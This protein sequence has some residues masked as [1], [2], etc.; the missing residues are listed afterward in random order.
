MIGK[1]LSKEEVNA[2]LIVALS[3]TIVALV[4][5]GPGPVSLGRMASGSLSNPIP[6]G[7][8]VTRRFSTVPAPRRRQVAA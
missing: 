6:E 3:G 4:A 2:A 8:V 1:L 7:V 5:N